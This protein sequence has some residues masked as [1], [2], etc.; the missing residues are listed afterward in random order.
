M[1]M[2]IDTATAIVTDMKE[3]TEIVME[4]HQDITQ[5]MQSALK[6][7]VDLITREDISKNTK[8]YRKEKRKYKNPSFK[9]LQTQYFW[10]IVNLFI[11]CEIQ[12]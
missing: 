1:G 5:A 2:E 7:N 3:D 8:K 4:K 6:S 11:F 9:G 12:I 10:V